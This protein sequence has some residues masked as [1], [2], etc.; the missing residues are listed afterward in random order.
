MGYF[1]DGHRSL[2]RRAGR[3]CDAVAVSIFV[4]PLQFGEGEDFEAYP[5]DPGRDAAGAEEEGVDLLFVPPVEEVYPEGY[6]PPEAVDPGPLGE[7]LEGASRP[8]HF[9]G[10]L[11]VVA[12]LLDLAGPCRAYFGEKD[13]QQ[14]FLVAR[15]VRERATPVEVVPC[16]TVRGS[17]GLALSSRN[18]YLS[19]EERSAA[20]CLYRA[21]QAA[22]ALCA[23]GEHGGSAIAA[24]MAYLIGTEPLAALDYAV[25][26][27]PETFEE[28]EEIGGEGLAL[29]AVRLGGTRLIDN[30]RLGRARTPSIA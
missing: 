22:E 10:V 12:R 21:L 15:M 30:L 27:D 23:G 1:H 19:P 4:N 28:A 7:R 2:M 29:L 25:V 11:T 20:L 13:A 9:R 18:S 3:E 8:G 17:D 24:E 16:T 26:V 14:L 6:P 5:R